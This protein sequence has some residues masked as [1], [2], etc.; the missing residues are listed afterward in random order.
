MKTRIK[1][2]GLNDRFVR[3][4]VHMISCVYATVYP[5]SDYRLGVFLIVHDV[6]C[7]SNH[8]CVVAIWWHLEGLIYDTLRDDGVRMGPVISAI[9]ASRRSISRLRMGP[10]IS[11]ISASRRSISRVFYK[12][13]SLFYT[14][15]LKRTP[16]W[17]YANSSDHDD[18]NNQR[19]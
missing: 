11:A 19:L 9:S 16:G 15:P 14:V 10:I 12:V 17:L 8:N 13:T 4:F 2:T 6:L 1:L 3:L 18:H 5:C 7:C